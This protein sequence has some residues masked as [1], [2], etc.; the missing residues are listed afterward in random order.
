M[1]LPGLMGFV[2]YCVANMTLD[3]ELYGGS[4][5]KAMATDKLLDW[6]DSI[7]CAMNDAMRKSGFYAPGSF[8]E[9]MKNPRALSP[10]GPRW[11]KAGC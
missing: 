2:E 10:W 7:G 11:A 6:M 1:N 3:V 4:K 9:L 5:V 8:R